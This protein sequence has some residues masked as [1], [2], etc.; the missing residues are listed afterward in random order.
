MA[1]LMRASGVG[2]EHLVLGV[3]GEI[4]GGAVRVVSDLCPSPGK[5]RADLLSAMAKEDS[6]SGGNLA[7]DTRVAAV[8]ERLQAIERALNGREGLE[9]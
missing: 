3:M 2:N 1:T 8:E 9:S 4:G 6:R 5:I 7:I